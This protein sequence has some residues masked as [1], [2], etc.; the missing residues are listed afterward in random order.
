[1]KHDMERGCFTFDEPSPETPAKIIF[2]KD[3]KT[4]AAGE[5]FTLRTERKFVEWV[6]QEHADFKTTQGFRPMCIVRL[7][8]LK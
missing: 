6:R 7:K 1:M 3:G 2:V 8:A 5:G 4:L